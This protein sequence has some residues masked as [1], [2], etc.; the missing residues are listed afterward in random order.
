VPEDT[1]FGLQRRFPGWTF[2]I[3][4]GRVFAAFDGPDG[5]I[6]FHEATCKKLRERLEDEG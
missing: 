3:E 2:F 4:G 1:I 6:W 5:R